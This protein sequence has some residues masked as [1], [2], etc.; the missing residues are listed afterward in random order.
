MRVD[1]KFDIVGG[2]SPLLSVSLSASQHLYTRSGTLVGI[3]G[4]VENVPASVPALA[5]HV[6]IMS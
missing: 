3:A 1:A 2:S 6:L 4:K 5:L